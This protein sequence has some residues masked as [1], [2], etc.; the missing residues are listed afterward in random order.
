MVA[1][2]APTFSESRYTHAVDEVSADAVPAML[3]RDDHVVHQLA[4]A[5]LSCT[6]E[7]GSSTG[8]KAGWLGV[9]NSMRIHDRS[10]CVEFT[11]L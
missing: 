8:A 6:S 11:R 7:R 9:E 5:E 1:S 4:E 3:I 10:R 2:P